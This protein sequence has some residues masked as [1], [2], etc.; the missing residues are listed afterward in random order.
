MFPYS[1]FIIIKEVYILLKNS[2]MQ[3]FRKKDIKIIF[4]ISDKLCQ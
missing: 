4:T 1:L 3:K 2:K